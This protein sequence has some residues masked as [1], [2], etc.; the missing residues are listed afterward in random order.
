[1]LT[2]LCAPSYADPFV[3]L[4][5]E[6]E[7]VIDEVSSILYKGVLILSS[8]NLTNKN[9][10]ATVIVYLLSKNFYADGCN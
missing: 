1:M 4:P 7:Y 5:T 6:G 3:V 9:A 10:P 8:D 2:I